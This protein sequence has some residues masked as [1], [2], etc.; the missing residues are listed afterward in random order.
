[1]NEEVCPVCK[2]AKRRTPDNYHKDRSRRDGLGW[3]CK[4]CADIYSVSDQLTEFGITV[5]Y[6]G[7]DITEMIQG[8]WTHM[9]F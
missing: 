7:K 1:M 6:V 4:A 9:T 8:D 5:K 2:Q 3:A